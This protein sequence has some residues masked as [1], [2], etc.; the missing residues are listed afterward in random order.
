MKGAVTIDAN[1][2]RQLGEELVT[3]GEQAILELIKNSYDADAEWV[4]LLVDT[5]N[6]QSSPQKKPG[7]IRVEDNG[8][9]MTLPHLHNGWL[10]ISLSLKRKIKAS[11]KKSDKGRTPLGDKGLGRLSTMKLGDVVEIQTYPSK[12]DGFRVTLNWS[13]FAPGTNLSDISVNIEKITPIG[14]TGTQLNIYNL[15][16]IEYWERSTS[17]TSLQGSLSKLISPFRRVPGFA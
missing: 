1:V 6:G 16:D 17:A 12:T 10:R 3:D 13:V 5:S 9:G 14:R 8:C 7:L 4:R 2:I 15:R 11:G